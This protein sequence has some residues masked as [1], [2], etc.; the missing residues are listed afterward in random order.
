MDEKDEKEENFRRI[1]NFGHTIGHSLELAS[2]YKLSHGEAVS[3]GMVVES[4]IS[5]ELGLLKEEYVSRIK[6]LLKKAN[7]PIKLPEDIELKKI[8]YGTMLDKKTVKKVPHY[9]LLEGI[10]KAQA[11]K[12]NDDRHDA[13]HKDVVFVDFGLVSGERPI[14]VFDEEAGRGDHESVAGTHHG[15]EQGSKEQTDQAG[16][17]LGQ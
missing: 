7:L 9:T 3:I 6:G 8:I 11:G 13:A 5:K 15:G 1:L 2:N 12:D 16:G 17:D 10:G 14:K 4:E